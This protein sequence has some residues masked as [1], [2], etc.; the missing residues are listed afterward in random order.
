MV[1]LSTKMEVKREEKFLFALVIANLANISVL[2]VLQL[3]LFLLKV[4]GG[5][6]EG[7]LIFP[8]LSPPP[9]KKMS[10]SHSMTPIYCYGTAWEKE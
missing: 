4:L 5:V 1:F 9:K 6:A 2:L 10:E 8:S 3:Q 7:M